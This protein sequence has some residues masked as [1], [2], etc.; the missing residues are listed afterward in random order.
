[1]TRS[2]RY[3]ADGRGR[4]LGRPPLPDDLSNPGTGPA[5]VPR[6]GNRLDI[7]GLRLA[8]EPARRPVPDDPL[9]LSRRASGRRRRPGA[10]HHDHLVD[11]LFGLI[12]HL[13]IGRAFLAGLSFGS[14]VVFKA[15]HREPRR[16]PRAAVQGAFAHRDFTPAE[17]WALRLGRLV[18]GTVERL[19][20]R[21]PILT[22]NSK[23]EFPA[24]LAG[25]LA[26]L[27]REERP[28]A[29][30][31]AGSSRQASRPSSTSGRSCPRFPRRSSCFKG[32]KTGSSRG[33]ISSCLKAALPRA[34]G[35]IMPT[36]GHQPHLTHAEVLARLIGDWLLPC[37][38]GRLHGRARMPVRMTGVQPPARV[39]MDWSTDDISRHGSHHGDRTRGRRSRLN[40]LDCESTRQYN[41]GSNGRGRND[42]EAP[43]LAT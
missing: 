28:D 35:V 30:P 10:D 17:R 22:Y 32:T 33:A 7:P 13:N 37:A 34:E 21:R 11:D 39:R 26:L 1:M 42:F 23:A 6:P 19:P 24:I 9:R 38:A 40:V 4:P 43:W 15:L 16:F 14:T 36:V 12:D 27:P 3:D 5:A 8:A 20:L 29:D 31:V 25:P 2:A 18:P 41:A